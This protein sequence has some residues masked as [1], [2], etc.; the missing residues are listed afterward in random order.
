MKY[1]SISCITP[2]S[3]SASILSTPTDAAA[4]DVGDPLASRPGVEVIV[5]ASAVFELVL[6]AAV[7]IVYVLVWT[8]KWLF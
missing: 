5:A 3:S 8:D 2:K 7:F 4:F 1:S 6:L